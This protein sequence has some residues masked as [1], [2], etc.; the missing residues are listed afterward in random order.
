[1]SFQAR[2]LPIANVQRLKPGHSKLLYAR[3]CALPRQDRRFLGRCHTVR[4][5]IAQARRDVG[6]EYDRCTRQVRRNSFSPLR[7]TKAANDALA[8]ERQGIPRGIHMVLVLISGSVGGSY[9]AIRRTRQAKGLSQ[10]PQSGTRNRTRP[11][12]H[13]KGRL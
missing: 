4:P 8:P 9:P 13:T 10:E 2:G 7:H 12:R 11:Q 1:M 5:Q 3:A 6:S